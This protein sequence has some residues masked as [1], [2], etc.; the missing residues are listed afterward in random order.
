[1]KI[2]RK[3]T[4]EVTVELNDAALEGHL[5][6]NGYTHLTDLVWDGEPV[7]KRVIGQT[8]ETWYVRATIDS[9]FAIVARDCMCPPGYGRHVVAPLETE[10]E[11]RRVM[12]H[13]Y[14]G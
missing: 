13:M 1:M 3:I 11:A 10:A 5:S 12:H 9:R 8:W 7:A 6:R 4:E 2:E 14:V